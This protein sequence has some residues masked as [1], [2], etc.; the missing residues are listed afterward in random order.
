[1]VPTYLCLDELFDAH[2]KQCVDAQKIA[3][4]HFEAKPLH[5]EGF[6]LKLLGL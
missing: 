4:K 3:I 5:R 6:S 2:Q 1:M